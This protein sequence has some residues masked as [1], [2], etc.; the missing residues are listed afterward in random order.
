MARVTSL[1]IMKTKDRITRLESD[2]WPY[3][4]LWMELADYIIPRKANIADRYAAGQKMTEKLFD[5]TAVHANE[6]LAAAMAGTLSN[7]ATRWFALKCR[8]DEL[9]DIKVVADWLDDSTERMYYAL[10]QS[11]FYSEIHENY[12]DLGGFGT[13]ALLID[14]NR[15]TGNL[16]FG[17]QFAG[18]FCVAENGYRRVDTVYRKPKMSARQIV[19]RWPGKAS[20]TIARVAAS[21][22]KDQRFD[23]VHCIHPREYGRTGRGVLA[24]DMAF[25][26]IYFEWDTGVI[27]EESGYQEWPIPVARWTKSTGESYGR[28]PGHTALP[29]IKTLN[30]TTEQKLMAGILSIRPP[31][32]AT[33]QGVIGK[34]SLRPAAINTIAPTI[35]GQMNPPLQPLFTGANIRNAELLEDPMQR[36]IH[37]IFFSD[38]L[39]LPED[40]KQ[41]TAREVMIRHERMQQALGPTL[42]RLEEELFNPTIERV[43]GIMMRAG[44]LAPPPRELLEVMRQGDGTIDIEYQGPL[45]RAQRS[46]DT[47]AIERWTDWRVKMAVELQD[48]SLLDVMDMDEAGW[49]SAEVTG[50]PSKVMRSKDQV[51]SL[52]GGRQAEQESQKAI[53]E[54]LAGAQEMKDKAP[55]LKALGEGRPG[56]QRPQAI[57]EMAGQ[58]MM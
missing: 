6:L 20:P 12:L 30:A 52:R 4:L 8:K 33:Q 28:G 54:R 46:S 51:G 1:E 47:M 3:L 2:R 24:E 42:G 25:A 23:I 36:Q 13:C 14:T 43:F 15:T 40:G 58:G 19:D 22:E 35:P 48:T 29:L 9:N 27:I 37:Q 16:Q 34:V 26:S 38:L 18:E 32:L 39:N 17:A 55:Y 44:R 21:S 31:L 57:P 11:N 45:A 53:D 49:H 5:S 56:I 7:K 50:V 10:A 41:M